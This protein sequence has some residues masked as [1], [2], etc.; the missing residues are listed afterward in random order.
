MKSLRRP[1]SLS[2]ALLGVVACP[3]L[4]TAHSPIEGLGTFYSHLLHPV[5]V[6][7]H[8]LLLTA[9]S[10][11]LGQQGRGTA[12]AAVTALGVMFVVG[13][14]MAMAGGLN[15]VREQV[16]IIAALIAGGIVCLDRPVPIAFAVLMAAGTGFAIGLDSA[17]NTTGHR[18]TALAVAG[19]AS[20]VLYVAVVIAGSTVA[21]K[22]HWQR[23]AMRIGGSWIFAVSVMVFALSLA[24]PTKRAVVTLG[25][26][27][28]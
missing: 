22:T 12:R 16:L 20:G 11:M 8:A 18:N 6:L 13:L 24:R 21:V 7:S 14:A 25:S 15:V 5:T 23:V 28:G 3:S 19:L 1:A 2:T 26:L 27:F 4:A 9:V 17:V 10:L